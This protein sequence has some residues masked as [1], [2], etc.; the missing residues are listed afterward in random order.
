MCVCERE[1]DNAGML[2]QM[3]MQLE[4]C[5]SIQRMQYNEI[6]LVIVWII[7][8][9]IKKCVELGADLIASW[10]RRF[11]CWICIRFRIGSERRKKK[12]K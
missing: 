11:R 8:L 6:E 4:Q 1:K 7:C 2:I 10:F 3:L 12:N 5:K 9:W